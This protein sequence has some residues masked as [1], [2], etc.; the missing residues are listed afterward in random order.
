MS[1]RPSLCRKAYNGTNPQGSESSRPCS[2]NSAR[3]TRLSPLLPALASYIA[4][5]QQRQ[6][7][8]HL[9]ARLTALRSALHDRVADLARAFVLIDGLGRCG[10][11]AA[12]EPEVA[13][14]GPRVKILS[15]SRASDFELD[16][17]LQSWWPKGT[18]EYDAP[19]KDEGLP[20]QV[21]SCSTPF[22][23]H[24]L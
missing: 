14:L 2:S 9:S 23:R 24:I 8:D 1:S 6:R 19:E 10:P 16:P 17:F 4:F 21:V 7:G 12:L 13:R 22:I 15:T 3:P 5:V 18:V 20:R 11:Q